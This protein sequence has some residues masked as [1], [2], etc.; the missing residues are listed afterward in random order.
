MMWKRVWPAGTH[1]ENASTSALLAG[2]AYRAKAQVQAL[3]EK[4][5]DKG[6]DRKATELV[7]AFLRQV[8]ADHPQTR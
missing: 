4:K 7:A 5:R 1:A 6:S 3:R 8:M 2:G